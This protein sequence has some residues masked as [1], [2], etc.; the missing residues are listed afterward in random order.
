VLEVARQMNRSGG[1]V[2]LAWALTLGGSAATQSLSESHQREGLL[3]HS[4]RFSAAQFG[5]LSRV[6]ALYHTQPGTAGFPAGGSEIGG[7]TCAAGTGA[8]KH[9]LSWPFCQSPPYRVQAPD[10]VVIPAPHLTQPILNW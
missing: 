10:S 8:A 5:Y 6:A 9:T 3:A 7:F 1:E 4:V 2:A